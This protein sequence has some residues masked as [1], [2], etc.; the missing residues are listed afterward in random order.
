[1]KQVPPTF[2]RPRPTAPAFVMADVNSEVARR[3]VGD[4][5]RPCASRLL[6]AARAAWF[7]RRAGMV[8]RGEV[9]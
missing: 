3:A 7:D 5:P 8:S 9:N 4:C 1:M 6:K 2:S